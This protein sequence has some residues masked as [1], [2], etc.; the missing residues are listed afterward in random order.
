MHIMTS[1]YHYI[2][3]SILLVAAC[4]GTNKA[5]NTGNTA[6][7]STTEEARGTSPK[8]VKSVQFVYPMKGDTCQFNQELKIVYANN[9][10]YKIASKES[11]PSHLS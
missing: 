1:C 7:S 10:R 6:V 9:K 8:Y 5:K 2:L 11:P 3:L 4:Q